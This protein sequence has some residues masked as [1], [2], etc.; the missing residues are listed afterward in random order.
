M[1]HNTSRSK[2]EEIERGLRISALKPF[3]VAGWRLNQV[4]ARFETVETALG[5]YER[6]QE[7]LLRCQRRECRR[8][9]EVDFRS[10]LQ[11]GHGDLPIKEVIQLLRCR[12]WGGCEL[13]EVS[14]IYPNGVPLV[15]YLNEPDIL[16]AI[17]CIGCSTRLL[18]PPAKVI[19]RL[20]QA[21]IGDGS[22]GILRLGQ[23]VR[24]PC[25]KCGGRR[26]SSETVQPKAA[27]T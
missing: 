20:V 12:H 15:A 9:V 21:G 17:T 3:L 18:L 10:A 11:A 4:H 24:G 7:M 27:G 13:A 14:A 23:V 2:R 8:R 5:F 6:G 1:S 22:T 25:R 26:F 16:V 19:E